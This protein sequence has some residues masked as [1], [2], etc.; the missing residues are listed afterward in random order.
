MDATK[1]SSGSVKW[2]SAR[3][4]FGFI[5]PDDGGEDLFV[6]QSSIRSDGF[7]TLSE[8][9][10][11]EFS[12]DL[13]EDGRTKA[14]DV[15][16]VSRSPVGPFAAAEDLQRW[17]RGTGG[18]YGGSGLSAR[19]GRRGGGLGYSNSGGYGGGMCYNCGRYGHFARDCYQFRGRGGG[20]GG[21]SRK[22]GGVG[23]YNCGEE[24]HFARDCP[25][26]E[27]E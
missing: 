12:V 15:V 8:G 25:N 13:G 27:Q 18:G 1:R 4:G 3:K 14:S 9:Q 6:H 20:G 26:A 16:S 24:G 2:F 7:R 10:L 11:V 23:C 17:R 5:A 21:G 19:G 22:Y